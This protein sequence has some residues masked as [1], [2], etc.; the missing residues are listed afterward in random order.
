MI[1]YGSTISPFVRK[2][3]VAAATGF[4]SPNIGSLVRA[5][6]QTIVGSPLSDI[7]GRSN[8]PPRRHTAKGCGAQAPTV[9]MCATS[10][11]STVPQTSSGD[12]SMTLSRTRSRVGSN[13]IAFPSCGCMLEPGLALRISKYSQPVSVSSVFH[14]AFG[15]DP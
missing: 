14:P 2:V 6:R 11:S 13:V 10:W 8:V 12:T 1:V 15:K 9:F 4:S 3:H 7:G 5:N